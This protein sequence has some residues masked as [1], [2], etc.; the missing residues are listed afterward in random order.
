MKM[1]GAP[2][3]VAGAV[4]LRRRHAGRLR[5]RLPG[6]EGAAA[7]LRR[8]PLHVLHR[9]RHRRLAGRGP[10]AQP[11]SRELQPAGTQADRGAERLGLSPV[12]GSFIGRLAAA[13]STQTLILFVLAVIF[14]VIL[15]RSPFGYMVTATGGNRRAAGYAGIN[16]D[17]VRFASLLLLHA[18]IARRPRSTSRYYPLLQPLRRHAARTRRHRRG[19]HRRRQ[20]LRRLRLGAGRARRRHGDHAD[21]RAAVAADHPAP[22]AARS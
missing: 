5:Q 3:L 2:P 15:W 21:A 14:A 19:G 4:R 12:P 7:G 6:H 1:E 8:D 20:H 9:P 11:V 22:T 16:T 13:L 17:R 18:G 10:P